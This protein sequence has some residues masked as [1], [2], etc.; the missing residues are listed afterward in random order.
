MLY[1]ASRISFTFREVT[2]ID[3]LH[4]LIGP[5]WSP[6]NPQIASI[7]RN[8]LTL[9]CF[10]WSYITYPVWKTY[11]STS[12]WIRHTKNYLVN[13]HEVVGLRSPPP[14]V[15][16]LSSKNPDLFFKASRLLFFLKKKNSRKFP[17]WGLG[18]GP[19]GPLDFYKIDKTP[20][21]KK[22]EFKTISY[23]FCDRF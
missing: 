5:Q 17:C 13:W 16:F 2:P 12:E 1:I 11:F 21:V 10:V 3:A 19:G 7:I 23:L 9:K 8:P 22:A 4:H 20:L 14:H 6:L 15:K 18:S